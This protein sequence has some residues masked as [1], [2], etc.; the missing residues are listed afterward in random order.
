ME[1]D[2]KYCPYCSKTTTLFISPSPND[3]CDVLGCPNK[4]HSA[5]AWA[6][7]KNAKLVA[8]NMVENIDDVTY[9]LHIHYDAGNS[10][11]F[12]SKADVSTKELYFNFIFP[13]PKSLEDFNEK[14]KLAKTFM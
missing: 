2:F 8:F 5:K 3:E 10:K 11:I 13:I 6:Y 9:Q 4:D 14:I 7:V 12:I 1:K